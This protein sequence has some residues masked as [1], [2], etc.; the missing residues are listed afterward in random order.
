MSVESA[1]L[2]ELEQLLLIAILQCGDEAYTV[3]I[4]RLLVERGGRQITRGALF[5]SLDRLENK[6]FV[7]SWMGEPL[8]VRGGRAR[9][10]FAVSRSGLRA[11][12]TARAAMAAM[13]DGL[14][15]DALLEPGK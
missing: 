14:D 3:S 6:G 1:H 13:S 8:A 12:R 15:L 4:R 9:R 11:L 5:T 2:G 10:Y 7:R